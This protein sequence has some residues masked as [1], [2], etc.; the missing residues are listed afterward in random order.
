MGFR[1]ELPFNMKT[2]ARTWSLWPSLSEMAADLG[3]PEEKLLRQRDAGDL[4]DACCDGLVVA[5]S[6][7]AGKPVTADDLQAHRA[8]RA[9]DE[10]RERRREQIA[11]FFDLAGGTD[12]V[13]RHVDM[14]RNALNICKHRGT[15]SRLRKFEFMALAAKINQ[16]LTDDIFTPI[17]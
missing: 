15:L 3:Q 17:R 9:S 1:Y 12:I 10:V 7:A 16:Q 6:A 5:K 2:Y 13:A 11:E 14:T 8:R 4:P